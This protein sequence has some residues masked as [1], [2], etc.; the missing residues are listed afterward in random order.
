MIRRNPFLRGT[1]RLIVGDGGVARMVPFERGIE[2]PFLQRQ[3]DGD[4]RDELLTAYS[5]D[6]HYDSL[7]DDDEMSDADSLMTA[8]EIGVPA[9]EHDLMVD[10]DFE[11]DDSMDGDME[12]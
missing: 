2:E 3:P 9:E 8:L 5:I 10:D 7:E 12:I 6:S 4:N 1:F 11:L